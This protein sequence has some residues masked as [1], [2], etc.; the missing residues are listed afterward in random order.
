[1]RVFEFVNPEDPAA[2]TR[3][4]SHVAR[5]AHREKR[6]REIEAFQNRARPTPTSVQRSGHASTS[7]PDAPQLELPIGQKL[8]QALLLPRYA[9]PQTSSTSSESEAS[10]DDDTTPTEYSTQHIADHSTWL[11]T[12][13]SR[14]GA[15]PHDSF[16]TVYSQLNIG[17]RNLLQWCKSALAL[18]HSLPLWIT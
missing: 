3:A 8:G 7:L 2:R 4:K 10:S 14:V 9:E 17:D 13:A 11:D 5:K 1:M 15:R 12:Y 6:L 18:L 16:W